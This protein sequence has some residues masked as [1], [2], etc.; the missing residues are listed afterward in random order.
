MSSRPVL[1]VEIQSLGFGGGELIEE[2]AYRDL[3]AKLV[4]FLKTP[5][6]V[7]G[8]SLKLTSVS[9]CDQLDELHCIVKETMPARCE[10]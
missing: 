7:G 1:K 5:M 8:F 2:R 10:K 3:Q 6:Y 9:L 4:E